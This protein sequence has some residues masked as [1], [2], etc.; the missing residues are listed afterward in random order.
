MSPQHG[1][2][3]TP[4][5]KHDRDST[6]HPGRRLS[7]CQARRNTWILS[8]GSRQ[9]ELHA[10]HISAATGQV[11]IFDGAH[12]AQCIV[13]QALLSVRSHHPWPTLGLHSYRPRIKQN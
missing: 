13:R 1:T 7:I 2:A 5:P 12:G 3:H 9:K 10:D 8:A 6:G 4:D 11:Q